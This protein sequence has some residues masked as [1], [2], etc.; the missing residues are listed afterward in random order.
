MATSTVFTTNRGQAVRLPA[1][2][3]FPNS[4]SLSGPAM[5]RS[6]WMRRKSAVDNQVLQGQLDK[7][8]G[9]EGGNHSGQVL[10]EDR[11]QRGV[12]DIPG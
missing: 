1:E 8:R 9:I 3:R 10:L 5:R 11:L 12:T 2:T 7:C 6:V 4:V